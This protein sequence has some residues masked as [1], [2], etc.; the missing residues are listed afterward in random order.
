MENTTR[1]P[2]ND[3]GK[4]RVI[5]AW[6]KEDHQRL[7]E[8]AG[9][10]PPAAIAKELGRTEDAIRARCK[11]KGI[12][13]AT[14]QTHRRWSYEEEKYLRE[15]HQRL[16]IRQMAQHLGRSYD[17]TA[18]KCYAMN[19]DCRLYANKN[20]HTVYSFEDVELCRDLFDEG[21]T[22]RQISEKMEVPYQRV[23]EW[24]N[25]RSRWNE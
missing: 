10:M 2:W 23:C 15:N 1:H 18:C 3:Y 16:T 25:M 7:V 21:L 8:L 4:P 24:V 22:I 13:T 11:Q 17:S 19:L 14:I 9:T 20:H 6:S 12:S 5:G